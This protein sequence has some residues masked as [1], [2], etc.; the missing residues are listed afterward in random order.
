MPRGSDMFA[1]SSP[2]DSLKDKGDVF[3][4][5]RTDVEL[6][7]VVETKPTMRPVGVKHAFVIS[8]SA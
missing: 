8:L 4:Q 6:V 2:G 7:V 1:M 3:G 5:H